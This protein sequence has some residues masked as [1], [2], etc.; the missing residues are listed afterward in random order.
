MARQK[1]LIKLEGAIGDLSFY[2]SGGEYYARTKGGVDADRIKNDPAFVRTRENG[3]EFGRAGKASKLLRNALRQLMVHAADNRVSNRLTTQMLKVIQ[4]DATNARGERTVSDGDPALLKGFEFNAGAQLAGTIYVPFATAVDRATGALEVSL[5]ALV[6][7]TDLAMVQDATHLR[8]GALGA[9]V[10]F[11]GEAFSTKMAVSDF[12]EIDSVEHEAQSLEVQIE[13]ASPSPIFLAFSI[14]F[15]QM[16]N[17]EAY[18]LKSGALNAM[19]IVA[20]DL[21]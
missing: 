17:G 12:V 18:P 20:V 13:A 21:P 15:F 1:G 7:T 16:V 19:A 6:P 10:D 3:S 4:A 8:F 5:P 2:K 11:E 9:T 14:E